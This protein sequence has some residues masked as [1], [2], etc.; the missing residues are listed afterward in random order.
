MEND[1]DKGY[2]T[3]DFKVTGKPKTPK[4][5]LAESEIKKE[6]P[7]ETTFMEGVQIVGLLAFG[8]VFFT[9]L[10]TLF[11]MKVMDYGFWLSQGL[12]VL[13]IIIIVLT[14][15]LHKEASPEKLEKR[16]MRKKR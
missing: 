7:K 11:F 3:D 6:E 15:G 10:P 8:Y 9:I 5:N 14:F 12:V 16:N 13:F 2:S 1:N 4:L